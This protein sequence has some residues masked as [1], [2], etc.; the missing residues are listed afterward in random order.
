MSVPLSRLSSLDL[1]RR[2]VAVRRRMSITLA[3]DD[4]CITQSAVSRQIRALE[5]L[6]G[7]RTRAFRVSRR[8][9]ARRFAPL[10]TTRRR[11]VVSS[12]LDPRFRGD[13]KCWLGRSRCSSCFAASPRK[14][15]RPQ[16]A[17]R[18]FLE[19]TPAA[20]IS[21]P[22]ATLVGCRSPCASQPLRSR[23]DR[24][25]GGRSAWAQF[26]MRGRVRCRAARPLWPR[27]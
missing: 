26:E 22:D 19:E 5:D 20:S 2:F 21:G 17:S 10:S 3:A 11:F 14:I 12:R 16:T 25:S 1:I 27:Q 15:G 18:K 7:S 24:F 23:V 6:L 8:Y 4:L 13:D 9:K